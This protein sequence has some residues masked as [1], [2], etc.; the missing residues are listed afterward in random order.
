MLIRSGATST[1]IYHT[2][3]AREYKEMLYAEL[4][5]PRISLPAHM[6]GKRVKVILEIMNN[7]NTIE[8]NSEKEIL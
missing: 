3:K 2:I 5:L 4:Q 6:I 8:D 7:D 1:G